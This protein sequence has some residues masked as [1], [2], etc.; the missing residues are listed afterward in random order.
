MQHD[1]SSRIA[2]LLDGSNR[3]A[4]AFCT[5]PEVGEKLETFALV[6]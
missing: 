5:L 3:D 2:M 1:C 4:L 6:T